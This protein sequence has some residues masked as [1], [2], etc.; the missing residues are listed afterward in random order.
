MFH[1]LMALEENALKVQVHIEPHIGALIFLA[2]NDIRLTRSYYDKIQ[3][4]EPF[5]WIWPALS[6]SLVG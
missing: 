3:L 4:A 2:G 5:C 6:D 1:D